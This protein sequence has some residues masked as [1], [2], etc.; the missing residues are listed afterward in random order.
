MNNLWS[1]KVLIIFVVPTIVKTGKPV[2]KPRLILLHL[3]V[4]LV[5]CNFVDIWPKICWNWI[6]QK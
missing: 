4:N 5:H 1:C 2:S 3:T 6:G